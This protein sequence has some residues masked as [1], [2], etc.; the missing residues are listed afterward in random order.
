MRR[1]VTAWSLDSSAVVLAADTVVAA[2]R[3]ILGKAADEAEARAF[4]R[5]L[6]GRRHRVY[7]GVAVRG[8][9]GTPVRIAESSRDL[10][11][12]LMAVSVAW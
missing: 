8:S 2:G 12:R 11:S 9:G 5:L 7:T 4:L 1:N 6:S 3:R 10:I